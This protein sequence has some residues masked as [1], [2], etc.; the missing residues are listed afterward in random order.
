MT[1]S[2]SGGKKGVTLTVK[3]GGGPV[4]KDFALEK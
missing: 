2:K 3:P 1:W 4:T